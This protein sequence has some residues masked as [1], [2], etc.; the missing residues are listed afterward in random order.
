MAS[1]IAAMLAAAC[2]GDGAGPTAGLSIDAPAAGGSAGLLTGATNAKASFNPFEMPGGGPPPSRDVIVNPTLSEVLKTGALPERSLGQAT[3]PVT[4]VKYASMTCPYCRK[5][6]AE[7]FP[8]LKRTYIDT[9]KVRFI[10]REFPLDDLAL[11]AF[12]VAR[13]VPDDKYFDMLSLLYEQQRTW[14]GQ[15]ARDE[16]LKLAK[17][18]GLSEAQFDECLKNEDLAKGILDI[19]KDGADKYGVNATPTF[20][21]NGKKMEGERD[22]EGFRKAIDEAMSS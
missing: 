7:V 3:A 22:I 19:R 4:L 13:C 18:A 15:N 5:F 10:A 14:A 20:Y 17:L 12:M 11:A 8:E 21:I 1:L 16:L 2:A 9:G 6:Q